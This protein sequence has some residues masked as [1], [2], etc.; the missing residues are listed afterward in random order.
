MVG[1]SNKNVIIAM[2]IVL[3]IAV[4]TIGSAALLSQKTPAPQQKTYIEQKGSDTMLELGLEWASSYHKIDT[5]T[6]VN[7]TGG[8]SSTGINLLINHKVTIAQASRAINQ[9]EAALAVANGVHPFEIPVA[10]DGISIIVHYSNPLTRITLDQL[11]GIYN[12]TITNWGQLGGADLAIKAYGRQSTSGTYAYFQEKVLMNQPY[13][14]NVTEE[15]TTTQIL[16]MVDADPAAIG[17]V[18]LGYTKNDS[19]SKALPLAK[20]ASDMAFEPTNESAVIS[21]QYVLSRYLYLYTDGVPQN[22]TLDYI[23]WVLDADG[24]QKIAREIGF[25][26]LPESILTDVRTKLVK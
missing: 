8:G 6:V 19:V 22:E 14:A 11:R 17:Y 10:I 26:G 20:T 12:G 9:S 1:K 2:G 15:T 3:V 7:V 25:Y 5:D 16:N 24:G 13:S 4:A 18:G 21:G 23:L